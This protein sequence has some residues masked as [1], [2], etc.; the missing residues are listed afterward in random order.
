MLSNGIIRHGRGQA[1]FAFSEDEMPGSP[2]KEA[3]KAT[4]GEEDASA[5]ATNEATAPQVDECRK[6]QP[7]HGRK[8]RLPKEEEAKSGDDQPEGDP[9]ASNQSTPETTD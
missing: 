7:E 2:D 5:R 8:R 1:L 6:I 3:D 9:A 4:R